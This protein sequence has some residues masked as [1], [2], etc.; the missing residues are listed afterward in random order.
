LKIGV[1]YHVDQEPI[2]ILIYALGAIN[3]AIIVMGQNQLIVHHVHLINFIFQDNALMNV[4]YNIFL[5]LVEFVNP[6]TEI[7][8]LV[9]EIIQINALHVLL[10][11]FYTLEIAGD[12]AH[13]SILTILEFASL[14]IR[15]V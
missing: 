9:T 8:Q 15:L 10:I 5:I 2:T 1:N 6:A 7:V 13:P 11:E 4:R 3:L 14:A 12:N